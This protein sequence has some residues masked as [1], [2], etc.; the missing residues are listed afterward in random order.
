[1]QLP[2]YFFGFLATAFLIVL[3]QEAGL[4]ITI[5]RTSTNSNLYQTSAQFPLGATTANVKLLDLLPVQTG[6]TPGF[7]G[8]VQNSFPDYKF[9]S[10]TNN[11]MNS[12]GLDGY[13][14]WVG[15]S[16]EG[17]PG[18]GANLK[19]CYNYNINSKK[20]VAFSNKRKFYWIQ[21]ISYK[22]I[23]ISGL[24]HEQSYLDQFN[25]SNN[26]YYGFGSNIVTPNMFQDGPRRDAD[27]N[28]GWYAEVY[29]VEE[30]DEDDFGDGPGRDNPD[31]D[32]L[33]SAELYLVEIPDITKP[34]TVKIYNGISWGWRNT[35]TPPSTGGGGGCSGGSGGGGCPTALG[36]NF[37]VQNQPL[38]DIEISKSSPTP[39][40]VPEPISV[41][42]LEVTSGRCK[43]SN[44]ER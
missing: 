42:R 19:F 7:I 32:H 39:V 26:P 12:I 1:M 25:N 40:K 43:F 14:A 37:T 18:V 30:T 23:D 13:Q 4:G 34:K 38:S 16:P 35:V 28:Q 15:Y 24:P 22:Y 36:N 17:Y 20:C 8:V 31:K 5:T 44:V 6:G 2:K 10:N 3:K 29:L 33:W 11:L 41:Y 21:T 9:I 27:I